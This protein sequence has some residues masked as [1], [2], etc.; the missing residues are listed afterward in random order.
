MPLDPPMLSYGQFRG[1]F[2]ILFRYNRR[3]CLE[4]D[5]SSKSGVKVDLQLCLAL[6]DLVHLLLQYRYLGFDLL[7]G[8]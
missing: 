4:V 7:Q 2:G 5:A 3:L 8:C 6:L 1:I